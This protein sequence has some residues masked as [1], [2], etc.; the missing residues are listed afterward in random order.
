MPSTPTAVPPGSLGPMKRTFVAA[1]AAV[2][3][4][5]GCSSDQPPSNSNRTSDIVFD[6]INSL[7]DCNELQRQFDIA[8]SNNQVDYM[9]AADARMQSVGCY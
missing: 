3:L 7:T 9:I 5:I 6:R 8:D 4:L 1:V 2:V